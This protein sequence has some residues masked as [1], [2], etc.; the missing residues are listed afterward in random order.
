MISKVKWF[1]SRR[2]YCLCLGNFLRCKVQGKYMSPMFTWEM[3]TSCRYPTGWPQ[4]PL[5]ICISVISELWVFTLRFS[6]RKGRSK[7]SSIWLVENLQREKPW[8]IRIQKCCCWRNFNSFYCVW[9]LILVSWLERSEQFNFQH[10]SG[11]SEHLIRNECIWEYGDVVMSLHAKSRMARLEEQI[12]Q[13]QMR[14]QLVNIWF[15]EEVQI[16]LI[17]TL[18]YFSWWRRKN[19]YFRT[20]L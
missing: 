7:S 1:C 12:F 8:E 6:G 20:C 4:G 19:I 13:Q 16:I 2:R 3:C 18:I 17:C 5:Q 9:S 10:L 11:H 14:N 15:C